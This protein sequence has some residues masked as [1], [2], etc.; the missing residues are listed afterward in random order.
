MYDRL[1][2]TLCHCESTCENM[3][4]FVKNR[5]DVERRRRQLTLLRDCA[6]IC[7]LTQKY[8]A[9]KSPFSRDMAKLCASVCEA[10]GCECSRFPDRE[11]QNCACI[12][13]NCARECMEFA[14]G[15]AGCY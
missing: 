12:C 1:L 8:I 14:K 9:R 3:T 13:L 2:N 15:M 5:C 4:H 10:C 11:S 6:D 7:G